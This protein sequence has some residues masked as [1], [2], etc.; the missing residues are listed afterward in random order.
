MEKSHRNVG[1]KED[2]IKFLEIILQNN[3]TCQDH[4]KY[5]PSQISPVLG[6]LF[7]LKDKVDEKTKYFICQALIQSHLNYL[8]LI[9]GIKEILILKVHKLFK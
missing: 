3:L 4:V 2:L 9:Y 1:I 7:K 6:V 5:V 8:T